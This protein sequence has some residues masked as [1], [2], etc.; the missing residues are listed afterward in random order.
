ML[1][2]AHKLC[3]QDKMTEASKVMDELKDQFFHDAVLDQ[4]TFW[5]N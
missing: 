4:H 2:Q 3:Q 5:G 1:E